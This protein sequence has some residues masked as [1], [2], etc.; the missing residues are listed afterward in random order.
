MWPKR[1]AGAR[2]WPGHCGRDLWG[3][4]PLCS[5]GGEETQDEARHQPQ[6][7][8]TNKR[9]TTPVIKLTFL[10]LKMYKIQLHNLDQTSK[11]TVKF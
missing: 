4:A 1:I 11:S 5:E 2:A 8:T 3:L 10:S 7:M 9:Q 6:Q